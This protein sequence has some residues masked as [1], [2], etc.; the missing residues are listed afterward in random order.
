MAGDDKE[1]DRGH[2]HRSNGSKPVQAASAE[3]TRQ[4]TEACASIRGSSARFGTVIVSAMRQLSAV[5]WLSSG[6]RIALSIL[7]VATLV[8]G[9]LGL[10]KIS[11]GEKQAPNKEL[12][13][14]SIQRSP[15]V[16]KP[17]SHD[18]MA[19]FLVAPA[20]AQSTQ[21]STRSTTADPSL[22][23]DRGRNVSRR[24]H[25]A[26]LRLDRF[27]IQPA[28]DQATRCCRG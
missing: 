15:A 1:R 19:A 9:V 6:G 26:G 11:I 24:L 5:P 20:V 28:S 2:A 12:T 3:L 8:C 10:L 14:G 4:G 7:C 27:R 23:L 18:P 22:C 17:E 13:T 21:R 16:R 25:G